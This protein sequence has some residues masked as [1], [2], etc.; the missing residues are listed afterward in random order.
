MKRQQNGKDFVTLT[1]R[2]PRQLFNEV[3]LQA[4]KQETSRSFYIVEAI[5][6]FIK[7]EIKWKTTEKD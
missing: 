2:V 5:N 7:E 4:D 6:K 1:L 3:K